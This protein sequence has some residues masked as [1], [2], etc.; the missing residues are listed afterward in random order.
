MVSLELTLWRLR[1]GW[2]RWASAAER[3]GRRVLWASI[4]SSLTMKSFNWCLSCITKHLRT[5]DSR[6]CH[7]VACWAA[8]LSG[9]AWL[10]CWASSCICSELA[11]YWG[12]GGLGWGACSLLCVGSHPLG[13]ESDSV[14]LSFP[15][16]CH[17]L[18]L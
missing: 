3:R 13:Q 9:P 12:A 11:G 5:V 1:E 14:V 18:H 4:A 17:W 6:N 15:H 10:A 7:S 2:I 16:F 8:V